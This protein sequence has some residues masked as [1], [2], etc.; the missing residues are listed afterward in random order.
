[1][2]ASNCTDD[3]AM[4]ERI[5]F[6]CKSLSMCNYFD[7]K[8]RFGLLYLLTW[9]QNTVSRIY[10]RYDFIFENETSIAAEQFLINSCT[11]WV[12]TCRSVWV[13]I[14]WLRFIWFDW[15]VVWIYCSMV[16]AHWLQSFQFALA[17]KHRIT[18]TQCQHWN[19]R[20]LKRSSHWGMKGDSKLQRNIHQIYVLRVAAWWKWNG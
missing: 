10:N 15:C 19:E 12:Y 6:R 3:V 11:N 16:I 5:A 8:F 20:S 18:A 13:Y 7:R 14:I 9:W 1:M 2:N 4:V 17:K